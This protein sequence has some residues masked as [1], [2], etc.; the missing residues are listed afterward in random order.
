MKKYKVTLFD[1]A[2]DDLRDIYNF[3]TKN[4]NSS[5]ASKVVRLLLYETFSLDIF[6]YANPI[7]Y[8]TSKY[9]IRKKVVCKRYL[10]YFIIIGNYVFI[11]N[12]IDG[13][14]N[15]TPNNLFKSN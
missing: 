4:Y 7:C 13:R 6:P 8:I 9:I 2:Y 5:Y 14:R 10:I 11:Y 3:Y 1:S 12:I 15:I